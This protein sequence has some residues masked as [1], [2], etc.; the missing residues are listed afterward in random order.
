MVYFFNSR[1]PVK[2]RKIAR[3]L[4]VGACEKPSGVKGLIKQY[5]WKMT[6]LTA[7]MT[8]NNGVKLIYDTILVTRFV[9]NKIILNCN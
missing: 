2:C 6:K 8:F 9:I 1:V 7:N 3:D 4:G 5:N